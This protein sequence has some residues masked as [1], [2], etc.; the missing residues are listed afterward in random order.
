MPFH[1]TDTEW[2]MIVVAAIYLFECACWVRREAICLGTVLGRFRALP[3]PSFMG[4]E[5]YKLVMGNPSPLARCFVCES[6]PIA[7]SPEGICLPEGMRI[8][9]QVG[10]STCH[11]AFDAIADAIV[12][13]RRKFTSTAGPSP[14]VPRRSRPSGWRRCSGRRPPPRRPIAAES[15]A[16]ISTAGPTTPPPRSVLP[17]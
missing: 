17:N 16:S 8:V 1:L 15:S 10:E 9:V 4:N 13:S 6:W 2:V 5:R 14:L 3:S 11:V 12:P 7:V